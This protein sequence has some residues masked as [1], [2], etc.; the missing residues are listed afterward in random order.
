MNRV[1]RPETFIAAIPIQCHDRTP[2]CQLLGINGYF[3]FFGSPATRI[4]FDF[5]VSFLVMLYYS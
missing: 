5:L 4:Y 1:E 2:N 3:F